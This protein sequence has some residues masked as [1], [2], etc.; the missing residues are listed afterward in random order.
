M[1]SFNVRQKA[2]ESS[3]TKHNKE[4]NKATKAFALKKRG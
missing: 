2:D 3:K 1:N 4:P